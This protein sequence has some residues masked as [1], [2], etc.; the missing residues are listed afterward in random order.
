MADFDKL[1][2][3]EL[4]RLVALAEQTERAKIVHDDDIYWV[5]VP[6]S[7]GSF[8]RVIGE[9]KFDAA[10]AARN[11]PKMERIYTTDLTVKRWAEC[12]YISVLPS[13]GEVVLDRFL[14]TPRGEDFLAYRRKARPVRWFIDI[15]SDHRTQFVGGIVAVVVA[16]I[17]YLL[18]L[19]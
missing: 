7:D 15:W 6:Q 10:L 2:D 17:L 3:G 5:F 9:T 4:R 8:L 11:L 1:T 13:R 14:L 16:V 12:G 19:N 18:A